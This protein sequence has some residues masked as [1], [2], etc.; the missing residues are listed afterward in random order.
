MFLNKIRV[1]QTKTIRLHKPKNGPKSIK[2]APAGAWGKLTYLRFIQ[3]IKRVQSY[4]Q[5]TGNGKVTFQKISQLMESILKY[6]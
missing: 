3:P 4:F 6:W 2:P 5:V 1:N